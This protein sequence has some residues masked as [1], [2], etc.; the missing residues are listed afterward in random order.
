[1]HGIAK[2]EVHAS[3]PRHADTLA[4]DAADLLRVTRDSTEYVLLGSVATSKYVRPLLSVF[5]YLLMF[6]SEF[7]GR[8]DMSRGGLLLRAAREGKELD[9]ARV[10][11]SLRR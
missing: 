3:S 5:G 8:G 7:L 1:M 2:V 11:T 4:G 9:Y 6:P 10:A